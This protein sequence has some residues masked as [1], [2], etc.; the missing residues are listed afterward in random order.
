MPPAQARTRLSV[1]N[2]RTIRSPAGAECGARG[3]LARTRCRARQGQVGDVDA[4]DQQHEPDHREHRPQQRPL[5]LHAE[6]AHR[7]DTGRLGRVRDRVLRRQRAADRVHL[8]ARLLHRDT[9]LQAADGEERMRRAIVVAF[10]VQPTGTH[11]SR[12]MPYSKTNDAGMTPTTTCALP[13][14]WMALPTIRGSAPYR[15][16]HNPVAEDDDAVAA[17]VLLFFQE[18]AA[19]HRPGRR[20]RRRRSRWHAESRRAAR[21]PPLPVRL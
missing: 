2:C 12:R 14:I 19:H 16:V 4:G 10:S 6:F 15:R 8:A 9:G 18:R 3:Q 5:L 21:P 17:G 7:L 1:S 20:A 11:S 13:S